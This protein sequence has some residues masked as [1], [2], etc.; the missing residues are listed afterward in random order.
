MGARGARQQGKAQDKA[1]QLQADID[2]RNADTAEANANMLRANID[3]LRTASRFDMDRIS[4]IGGRANRD[5]M[6]TGSQTRA[7]MGASNLDL[8][9]GSPLDA[10]FLGPLAEVRDN[11]QNMRLDKRQSKLNTNAAIR[12]VRRQQ[13]NLRREAKT[14]RDTA[15]GNA[16]A[17]SSA[18]RAGNINAVASAIGGIGNAA[19]MFIRS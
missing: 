3:D 16:R 18:A 19:S 13:F 12:D 2:R 6:A 10:A 7:R 14:L 17:G 15:G 8:S 4:R 1:F 11:L 5:A 9:F